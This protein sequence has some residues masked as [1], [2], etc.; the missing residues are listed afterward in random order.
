[1]SAIDW[2]RMKHD[3]KVEILNKQHQQLFDTLR[4]LY[5]AME[6]KSDKKALGKVIDDLLLYSKEH[7]ETE[8]AILEKYGY[9]DLE[10]HKKL[11]EFFVK[12]INEFHQAYD[13][14]NVMLYFN[15]AIFI[16]SWIVNHIEQVDKQYVPFLVEKGAS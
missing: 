11:H 2:N 6:D 12:K 3:V 10:E 14:H 7:L 4:A 5:A 9:P 1:M 8:E 13:D 16:K 15:M